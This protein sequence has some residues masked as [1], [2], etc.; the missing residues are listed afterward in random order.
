MIGRAHRSEGGKA[1]RENDDY[2]KQV[3]AH[4]FR[5]P[6]NNAH[7]VNKF[8]KMPLFAKGRVRWFGRTMVGHNRRLY[9]RFDGR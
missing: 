9:H 7:G 4:E 6:G 3:G 8:S 1:E 2:F 5:I